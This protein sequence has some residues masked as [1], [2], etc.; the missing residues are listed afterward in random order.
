MNVFWLI[1]IKLIN[2]SS[3]KWFILNCYRQ[4]PGPYKA[5]RAFCCILYF[6]KKSLCLYSDSKTSIIA[7]DSASV[8]LKFLI[9]WICL[10]WNLTPAH[11]GQ[12]QKGSAYPTEPRVRHWSFWAT[13]YKISSSFSIKPSIIDILTFSILLIN[14]STIKVWSFIETSVLNAFLIFS[15]FSL[16]PEMPK[17]LER[18]SSLFLL[19]PRFAEYL[20]GWCIHG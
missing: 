18:S 4:G 13:F 3:Y 1:N 11:S 14:Q 10:C 19:V 9:R 2:T 15:C 5:P 7:S 8:I 6:D 17:V 12:N 20:K 16:A